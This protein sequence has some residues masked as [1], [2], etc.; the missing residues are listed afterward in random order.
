[1]LRA[2]TCLNI[3]NHR[4]YDLRLPENFTATDG[5]ILTAKLTQEGRARN[6]RFYDDVG[7]GTFDLSAVLGNE[8]GILKWG[9]SGFHQSARNMKI[10]TRGD[11]RWLVADLQNPLGTFSE[12]LINLDEYLDLV[13]YVH[14]YEKETYYR[15]GA[16][17]RAPPARSLVLC[18][19]G[20]SNHFSNTNTNVVKFMELLKKEDPERQLVYYQTGVG[21]YAP[22]GLLTNAGLSL[23]TTLDKGFASF[24]Y[25]H[26]IDGYKFLMQ[27]YRAGDRISIFGFSRGAF[28][29]RA[30]AGMVHCVGLLPQHNI[31]H[32]PFAYEVYKNA[33]DAKPPPPEKDCPRGATPARSSSLDSQIEQPVGALL[34][35][36]KGTKARHVNPEDFK[37]TF[38]ISV[39]IDFVGVWDTVA[40]VGSLWP[41]T[42]PWI[43]Y[44][45]GIRNFR[46][47]LALDERR[48]NFIPS[49]W[50]HSR[51]NPKTQTALEV[52]FKGGHADVGGGVVP[53]RRCYENNQSM[54]SNISLRWMVRQCFSV[55]T[56][57]IF[58]HRALDKY[59]K[60]GVLEERPRKDT[61]ESAVEYERRLLKLST[62]LDKVDIKHKSY[63]AMRQYRIWNLLEFLPS[64]KPTQTEAGLS[65]TRRPNLYKS[66]G[67]YRHA[68]SHPIAIHASVVDYLASDPP[69][70]YVPR[71]WWHG[72]ELGNH[73]LIADRLDGDGEWPSKA[74]TIIKMG[75]K[76]YGFREWA[77]SRISLFRSR[78][79]DSEISDPPK[80]CL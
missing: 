17:A 43:D 36:K 39:A 21:T 74:A 50:D 76:T 77:K 73:P 53:P 56:G 60:L 25:Q 61:N 30:L 18:F 80:E 47:A 34:R 27:T 63:D 20:T 46:Q 35:C 33:S 6:I 59:R 71:A 65:M 1:M 3:P 24:L 79:S 72:Y 28:T 55:D 26:V 7:D 66:R 70:P 48:A 45:P 62:D 41:T 19:D 5:F 12:H 57:I 52:W 37:K 40:S 38:C 14:P 22:P 49:V 4:L 10:E 31:E 54:L 23:A 9:S 58:D 11:H 67:A 16:K 2:S 69:V 44:N 15:L 32:V 51:T 64:A 13:E 29:A 68:P 8:N 78:T 75:W 42:L